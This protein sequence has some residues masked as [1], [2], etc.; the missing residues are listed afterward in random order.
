MMQQLR[1]WSWMLCL[2]AVL[3]SLTACANG[4]PSSVSSDPTEDPSAVE[5]PSATADAPAAEANESAIAAAEIPAGLPV[6]TGPATVEM[7]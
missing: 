7:H 6:L 1:K 3:V 2:V 4:D 5:S